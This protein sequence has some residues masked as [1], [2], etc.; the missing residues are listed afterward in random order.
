[1]ADARREEIDLIKENIEWLREDLDRGDAK[2]IPHYLRTMDF[3]LRQLEDR[4]SSEEPEVAQGRPT[5]KLGRPKSKHSEELS[6]AVLEILSKNGAMKIR[7]LAS[8][9][10]K[11]GIS[12]P[13]QGKP[14]N[15]IVHLNRMVEVVRPARGV[16]ALVEPT[17]SIS[18]D[19]AL[20]STALGDTS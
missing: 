16:Y 1:M 2:R 13:G 10:A 17:T 18:G 5:K 12:L 14:A 20:G 15:L 6:R 8:A 4:I 9:L 7:D 11:K 19:E 3:C